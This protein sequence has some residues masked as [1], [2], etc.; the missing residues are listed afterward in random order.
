MKHVTFHL[1]S[2]LRRVRIHGGEFDSSARA[3]NREEQVRLLQ[4]DLRIVRGSTIE[5]KQMSTKT[6][7]KRIALVAVAALGFGVLS[8]APSSALAGVTT[9]T[10]AN[11]GVTTLTVADSTKANGESLTG[12]IFSV[13]GLL[14][15]GADTIT[16]AYYTKS[17]SVATAFPTTGFLPIET[18]TVG[19]FVSGDQL[20]TGGVATG[21]NH[22][23]INAPAGAPSKKV[24]GAV[25]QVL[26]GGAIGV[27][28]R[29]ATSRDAG[30][31]VGARFA[32]SVDTGTAAN[33]GVY[34]YTVV[35]TTYSN[36]GSGYVVS[37]QQADVT[38]TINA[39]P[40]AAVNTP[41]ASAA[42]AVIQAGNPDA[43]TSVT[44]SATSGS[45][46]VASTPIGKILVS[47]FNAAGLTAPDTVTATLTGPGYL[48]EGSNRGR[49]LI[50]YAN[51]TATF[52]VF[53][54][55]TSGEG[56][57]T[58]TTAAGASF[59]KK[60]TFFDTKP[61]KATAVVAK[62]FI[63]AGTTPVSD[64]FA[65]TVTDVLGNA[66]KDTGAVVT[67]AATDTAT[68]VGGAATCAWNVAGDAYHCAVA[69]K[70]ADK[71]GPVAYTFTATG[72][73][74]NAATKVTTSATVTFADNVATKAV[75]TGPATGTPGATVEYT[76]TLTE[77]NGYPVADQTYG[78]NGAGGALFSTTA[79]DTVSSGFTGTL[80]FAVTES[81]TAKSGVITSKGTLP[82]A[83]VASLSLTLIGDGIASSGAIDK[84]IGKTK[85]S[86]STEVANPG[87]DAATDAANEATDAANAATDAALA[88]AEA[89]DA[90]TT[91]AQEASDAVAALSESVTKLIAGLQAQIKSLAA[92]VA[93]IAKKVKA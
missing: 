80:P 29:D 27:T 36:T 87:V 10:V 30:G 42:K 58:I 40:A 77:K 32:L 22:A 61:S 56:T 89:A 21:P 9:L 14:T 45:F 65:I 4:A 81:F 69:G 52:S 92:V 44:D 63:K 74:V 31:N 34:T 50:V 25:W 35:A 19:T 20:V 83:G 66:I 75:L 6:T 37:A 55:G 91:A 73:G 13:S 76:L 64:V 47:N 39:Q 26:T 53:A 48:L 11:N 71:F 79:A 24:A 93:K 57:V 17:K 38:L 23:P 54:D 60:V 28:T 68:T 85:I 46:A 82:I 62:S 12:A 78:V 70:A 90:A 49:S 86:V 7:F 43:V 16:V 84:T 5:R 72:T 8:V 67:A 33:A 41:L 15:T 3:M 2:F 88:A 1:P 51:T 18:T 59:V